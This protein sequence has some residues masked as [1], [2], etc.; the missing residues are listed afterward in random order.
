MRVSERTWGRAIWK[1]GAESLKV[2]LATRSSALAFGGGVPRGAAHAWDERCHKLEL[3]RLHSIQ[4][5]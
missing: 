2:S 5:R 1:C 3:P 4:T